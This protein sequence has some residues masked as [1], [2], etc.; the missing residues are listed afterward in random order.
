MGMVLQNDVWILES[1]A[2]WTEVLDADFTSLSTEAFDHGATFDLGG[3]TW[4]VQEKAGTDGGTVLGTVEAVAGSGIK[5]TPASSGTNIYTGIDAPLVSTKLADVISSFSDDDIICV[6]FFIDQ[7]VAIAANYDGYGALIYEQSSDGSLEDVTAWLQYSEFYNGGN[8]NVKV[9]SA[10]LNETIITA[11]T[12]YTPTIFEMVYSFWSSYGLGTASTSA[13]T[14]PTPG[15]A[16]LDPMFCLTTA[17]GRSGGS[18]ASPARSINAAKARCGFGAF[19][20]SSGTSF[21]IY[22]KRIRILKAADR[23]YATG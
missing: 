19:K 7:A 21:Y 17:A 18:G 23:P 4:L 6:Q 22:L 8:R 5:L 15:A 11:A 10:S 14:S 13:S 2:A 9:G 1:D 20:V 12:S 3:A 16:G